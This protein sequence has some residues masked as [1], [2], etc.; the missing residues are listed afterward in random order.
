MTSVFQ[1]LTPLFHIDTLRYIRKGIRIAHADRPHQPCQAFP[2]PPSTISGRLST[3]SGK[4]M[5][6]CTANPEYD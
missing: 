5:Y 2:S 6:L 3:I 1:Q 4:D